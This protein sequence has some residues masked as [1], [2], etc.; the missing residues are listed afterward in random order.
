MPHAA[1]QQDSA[2][3]SRKRKAASESDTLPAKKIVQR[4]GAAG[5]GY[6]QQAEKLID[7]QQ[8]AIARADECA[9]RAHK[10]S[11]CRRHSRTDGTHAEL[12]ADAGLYFAKTC[13]RIWEVL[14]QETAVPRE[15]ILVVLSFATF[16]CSATASDLLVYQAT[17][18]FR[19]DLAREHAQLVSA[20]REHGPA[21]QLHLEK[22]CRHD[23]K[24][25]VPSCH[26][27]QFRHMLRDVDFFL[28]AEG[29]LLCA[30]YHVTLPFSAYPRLLLW[31]RSHVDL[32]KCRALDSTLTRQ[33]PSGL[34]LTLPAD[35]GQH[36]WHYTADKQVHEWQQLMNSACYVY[37]F[38]CVLNS[39][40]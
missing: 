23:R 22:R 35:Q 11:C 15:L 9:N 14:E 18:A 1:L 29:A 39:P 4:G 36:N 31:L 5:L 19:A 33:W 13:W 8:A 34:S 28:S 38:E 37:Y 25:E 16:T 24:D 40:L 20:V 6:R 26:Q 12:H 10:R 2:M 21:W 30:A 27:S 32:S 17:K 7:R 3:A